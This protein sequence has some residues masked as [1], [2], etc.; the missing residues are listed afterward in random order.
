MPT[1]LTAPAHFAEDFQL[2]A[3]ELNSAFMNADLF[4]CLFDD[5][6][7]GPLNQASPWFF[8]TVQDLLFDDLVLT[9]S[10]LTDAPTTL[11]RSNLTLARLVATID[12]ARF[13]ETRE[14]ADAT[15]RKI[16][17]VAVKLRDH[18][19]KRLAHKDLEASHASGAPAESPAALFRNPGLPPVGM[20][21]IREALVLAE[22]ALSLVSQHHTRT[23]FLHSSF[24]DVPR[25]VSNLV[26]AL[27]TVAFGTEPPL[28]KRP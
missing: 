4:D 23:P 2:L 10:R 8:R 1:T 15:L 28:G 24:I 21:H 17:E 13:S 9:I 22:Q 3:A 26:E 19:N 18:R 27:S 20:V 11:G 14:G 5:S 16:K 25:A 7:S 12:R 6:N